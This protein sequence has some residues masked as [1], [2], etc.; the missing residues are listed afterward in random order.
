M[1]IKEAQKNETLHFDSESREESINLQ[2][3]LNNLVEN[4]FYIREQYVLAHSY[5]V[6]LVMNDRYQGYNILKNQKFFKMITKR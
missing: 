6:D 1:Q 2:E 4:N 5:N 3:V